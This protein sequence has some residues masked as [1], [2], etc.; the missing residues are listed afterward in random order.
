MA[1]SEKT[2]TALLAEDDAAM[3]RVITRF[4]TKEG[5]NVIGAAT[6]TE[7][8]NHLR[9]I[10]PDLI[11]ADLRMPEIDGI[12]LLSIAKDEFSSIPFIIVSG[13]GTMEDVIH[14]LRLGAWDYLTKPIQP[15][16]LLIHSI[17]RVLEK[18]ELLKNMY[19]HREYLEDI[20]Q[21]R[22]S[23]LLNQNMNYAK[24]LARRQQMEEQA[25][26]VENEWRRT[27][28]ALPEM[29]AII[30]K[31][32]RITR[33]NKSMLTF[34]D[35]T[36]AELIGQCCFLCSVDND[37][38]H[39]AS[40]LNTQSYTREMH[41]EKEGKDLELKII[42]YNSADG[43]WLGSI[44]VFRDITEMKK[45]EKEQQLRQ[46]Q[47]LH[48]QKLESVG[49]LASGIAHE[50][51]TPTQF[52]SSNIAFFDEAFADLQSSINNI[53]KACSAEKVSTQTILTHL[54]E[55]DWN[56]L[57]KEI[58]TAIK[59]SK[60]GLN[61]VSSIVRAM[62]EF[63][64]PGDREAQE[65]DINTIIETTVTVARNEWKYVADV[66]LDLDP[67][68]PKISCLSDE[69]GQVILNLLV[70]SA[71]A[72]EDKLGETPEEDKGTITIATSQQPCWLVIRISDT[73]AGMPRHVVEK[74]FEPFFT[75][76]STGKGT[77]QGL[78]IAY[79]VITSKHGGNIQVDSQVGQ[80]TTFTIKLPLSAK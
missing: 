6:G 64:H 49:Q 41:L 31:K 46:S 71:H 55:A 75:T 23:D 36:E 27:V 50:I 44:H 77:G 25:R 63:S 43:K 11:I 9:E 10:E 42:P 40:L 57:E 56:Y 13:V 76:K 48:S 17:E 21:Q 33:V 78:A 4:L 22:T 28:D 20:V 70:N 47:A 53:I 30:D 14:G 51:N 74:I 24:E 3:R 72:I 45:Q 1:A 8:L 5:Y 18:A 66:E 37:C 73:G 32:R 52:V 35:K 60:E 39:K 59:Q 61:R 29:I 2:T 80:G 7:A 15:L 34:L 79:D 62:K 67:E 26:I 16:E 19:R 12:E 68:L 38:L 54:E 58:P 69:M 65:V